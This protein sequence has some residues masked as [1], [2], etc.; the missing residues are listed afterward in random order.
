[1]GAILTRL[2]IGGLILS[3]LLLFTTL[4]MVDLGNDYGVGNNFLILLIHYL[5]MVLIIR[6][7]MKRNYQVLTMQTTSN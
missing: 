5:Q 3:V 4:F 7:L 2:A 6:R 1:M